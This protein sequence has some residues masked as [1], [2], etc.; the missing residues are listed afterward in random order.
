[1]KRIAIIVILI[2]LSGISVVSAKIGRG[3]D[4]FDGSVSIASSNSTEVDGWLSFRK[5]TSNTNTEYFISSSLKTLSYIKFSK[6]DTEIKINDQPVQK[7]TVKEV[8]S[9]PSPLDSPMSF[10]DVT[11]LVPNELAQQIASAQRI[12][13]R[14][15]KENSAPYVYVLPDS[16]LAEWQEVINAEK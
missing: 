3:T 8:S 13:I 14:I 9:M 12:A 10:I 4:S 7:L 11:V 16:V 2:M 1:M 6:E 5:K 15:H